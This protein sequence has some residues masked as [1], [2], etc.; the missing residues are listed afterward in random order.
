MS[1]NTGDVL[2]SETRSPKLI[3]RS[4]GWA[5]RAKFWIWMGALL[6]LLFASI[7]LAVAIGPV[8]IPTPQVWRIAFVHI[9][10]GIKV[11]WTNAQFNIVWLIRFPRVLLAVFVGASLAVVGVT[12]QALV[13]NPLADPYVLGVSSGASVGAV[14]VLSLGMFAFAGL[15]AISLAAFV[16]SMLTFL[17]VFLLARHNGRLSATRLIL[18]GVAVSYLFSGLTSFITLTSADRDLARRVL[19]WI[20]GGLSGTDWPDLALPTVALFIGTIYL[21]LQARSLNA[22]IIGE[23]SAATLGVNTTRFRQQLFLVVSLLTGVMVAVSGAIGFVG[24]MIPHMVRFV[25]GSD[26]RRVL[27][28][29]VL[30]GGIFLVW[31]DVIARTLFAPVELPIGVIT[32][33]FGAPFFIWLMRNQLSTRAG[34]GL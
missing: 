32:S 28:V 31:A 26:H 8:E 24:L 27:P 9:F 3:A 10:P 25:I 5:E 12:M 17:L 30:L 1:T 23:E 15:Y 4:L 20:L 22:L 11:D 19:F 2:P 21:T 18:S 33:L 7:T 6:A 14:I 34:G 13:R 16:G 29:S